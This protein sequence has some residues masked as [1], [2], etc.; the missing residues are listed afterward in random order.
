MKLAHT[1]KSLSEVTI[2]PSA[3]F[4]LVLHKEDGT[5][6]TMDSYDAR[7]LNNEDDAISKAMFSV[8]SH[9]DHCDVFHY[10]EEFGTA[11]Y[12]DMTPNSW[13]SRMQVVFSTPYC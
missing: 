8:K 5:I 9:D 3:A 11:E 10:G 1:Y 2:D 4:T 13:F 12:I 6:E 7:F